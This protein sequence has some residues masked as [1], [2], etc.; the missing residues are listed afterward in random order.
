MSTT[1]L[2]TPADLVARAASA[3]TASRLMV[4]FFSDIVGSTDLKSRLGTVEYAEVLSRHDQIFRE[5]IATTPGAGIL[6]DT[7]DGFFASFATAS[8][9]VRAAL[10]LQFGLARRAAPLQ[11]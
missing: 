5:I 1:P 8:D 6:K 7:G 2:D 4:L 9:A 3:P 10:R 11:V